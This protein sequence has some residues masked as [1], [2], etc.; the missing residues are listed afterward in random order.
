MLCLR[1]C[2]FAVTRQPKRAHAIQQAEIHTLGENALLLRH[3]IERN[4]V[5]NRGSRGVNVLP[6]LEGL[7]Q[8]RALC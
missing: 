3:L 4:P 1:E 6:L 5:D 8:R 7:Q 2:Q